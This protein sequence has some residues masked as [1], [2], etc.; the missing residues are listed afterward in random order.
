MSG[1]DKLLYYFNRSWLEFTGRSLEEEAGNGWLNNI[2][3]D[4]LPDFVVQFNNFI[5]RREKFVME[6]RMRR[7]DGEYR[8]ISDSGAPRF[9]SHEN[10]EGYIGTCVDIHERK[11]GKE[12]L[13]ELVRARTTSLL[14]AN[15]QL[16]ASNHNLAEFAYVASHD[17][18]EPLR[19][20]K[21]FSHLLNEESEEISLKD[22]HA[23]LNKIDDSAVRM[24]H[25][26]EDLLNYS[27][28]QNTE[29]AFT[30]T[31]L[32]EVMQDILR[33]FELEIQKK[34]AVI[35]VGGLPVLK[36]VPLRMHQLFHNLLS[37]SLKFIRPGV[38]PEIYIH[39]RPMNKSEL[40]AVP[41]LQKDLSYFKITFGDNGIG[42]KQEFAEKAFTIFQRL[43]GRSEYDGTGIGLAICRKIVTN[44]GGLISVTS[45]ENEGT[46]FTIYLPG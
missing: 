10:F 12:Q 41:E 2:H 43:N 1:P 15:N 8:W 23:Y 39:S 29:E 27:R 13:E 33:E 5:D 30:K 45:S 42:F 6:Y 46:E 9:S 40:K 31:D 14:I 7:N 44:H 3:P 17:L 37:N 36:A 18:Q 4:D 20:I 19:K 35:H 25:L 24:G 22:L 34:Q 28:L 11:I 21:T 26:I 32:N 38:H 16:E